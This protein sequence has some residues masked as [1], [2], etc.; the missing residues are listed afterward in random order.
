MTCLLLDFSS[1]AEE[2]QQFVVN[3]FLI[4][5]LQGLDL[6]LSDKGKE[7]N[8]ATVFSVFS[9]T[10]AKRFATKLLAICSSKQQF[11]LLQI[12]IGSCHYCVR[13]GPG[14]WAIHWRTFLP[15]RKVIYLIFFFW[16]YQK[17]YLF[18]YEKCVEN[19]RAV[20]R[21]PRQRNSFGWNLLQDARHTVRLFLQISTLPS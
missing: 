1:W 5:N 14:W 2:T 21:T 16:G 17:S 9:K 18:K 4:L 7:W 6:N 11:C 19:R 12:E 15:R 10:K 8:L 13:A 3:W 20:S